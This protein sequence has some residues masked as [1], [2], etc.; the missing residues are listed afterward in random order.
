MQVSLNLNQQSMSTFGD[1]ALTTSYWKRLQDQQNTQ[2]LDVMMPLCLDLV[3][4]YSPFYRMHWTAVTRICSQGS[5]IWHTQRKKI[6]LP[7]GDA[8]R[9]PKPSNFVPCNGAWPK[10]TLD[11]HVSAKWDH[12]CVKY[13]VSQYQYSSFIFLLEASGTAFSCLK[14]WLPTSLSNQI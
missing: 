10:R 14:P 5:I 4:P 3:K 9:N 13:R 8:I 6:H 1:S 11:Q 7:A 12:A 2:H